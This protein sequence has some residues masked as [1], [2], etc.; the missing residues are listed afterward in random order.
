[1]VRINACVFISGKGSNLKAIFKSSINDNF[2]I[3]IK[4]LVT[5]NMNA[6]GIK[7]AKKADIPY[8]Y[9]KN[10]NFLNELKILK[11]IK[12]HKISIILL[13][14]YMKILSKNFI[15]AFGKKIINIHPSLLPKYKGLNTYRRILKD[16]EKKSGCTVHYVNE[17]LDS[18]KIILKKIFYVSKNDNFLSLKKKTQKIEHLAYSQAIIKILKR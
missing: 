18:G 7:F 6:D 17:K 14:G 4:L 13:A 2:P 16:N 5:S 3:Q 8:V 12:Q 10:N 1:M 9:F 11:L 15:K